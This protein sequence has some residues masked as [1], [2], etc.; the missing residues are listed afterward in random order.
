MW[1][2]GQFAI[3]FSHVM[4]AGQIIALDVNEERLKIAETMGSATS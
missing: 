3:G 4:G 1:P 2:I